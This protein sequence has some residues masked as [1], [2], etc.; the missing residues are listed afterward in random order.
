MRLN[1]IE[2]DIS[3]AKKTCQ[4]NLETA[5]W[6]MN[7]MEEKRENIVVFG[8]PEQGNQEKGSHWEYDHKKVDQIL[9]KIMGRKMKFSIK[10]RI[11]A[12]AENKVRPIVVKLGN[13]HEKKEIL[14][15]TFALQSESIW[16]NVYIKQDLT[17]NQRDLL[18]K[19]EEE[20]KEEAE[21]RNS[22]LKDRENWRWIIKG[23]GFQRHLIKQQNEAI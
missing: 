15:R 8:L 3:Q 12:K 7:E 16:K 23:K 18:K 20:L 14:G 9:E 17:K 2:A 21:K 1:T 5:I 4:S 13:P 6:E 19:Q 22:L 10:F 11:G